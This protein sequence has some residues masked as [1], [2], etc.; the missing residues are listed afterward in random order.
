MYLSA[1]RWKG[2]GFAAIASANHMSAIVVQLQSS[3]SLS[4]SIALLSGCDALLKAGPE[5]VN[6]LNQSSFGKKIATSNKDN[7]QWFQLGPEEAFYLCHALRCLKIS[8]DSDEPMTDVELWDHLRTKRKPFPE[9]YKAY[10]HLR[11]KNW[12]VRSGLQYGV[13]FVA[14][15]HHPALVHSE[16]AV[17]VVSESE[18]DESNGRLRVWSDLHCTLRACRGVAKTLLVLSIKKC[19]IGKDSLNCLKELIVNE[20]AIT[21]RIPEQRHEDCDLVEADDAD[22]IL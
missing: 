20:R 11:S 2:K 13:Y 9:F 16:Y 19:G 4:G 17:L 21:R 14:Y 7:K 15:R 5:L 22:G 10:S 3:L 8:R 6:L 1:P 12:I 18:D